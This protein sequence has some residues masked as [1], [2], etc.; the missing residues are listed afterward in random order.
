VRRTAGRISWGKVG[1]GAVERGGSIIQ[2]KRE[3]AGVRRRVATRY[4]AGGR[5]V[6]EYL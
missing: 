1:A 2:I 4:L 3:G 6:I 5:R